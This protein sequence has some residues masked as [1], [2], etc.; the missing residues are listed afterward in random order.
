MYASLN[1]D[2]IKEFRRFLILKAIL[3]DTDG[4]RISPSRLLENAWRMLLLFPMDYMK[5]CEDLIPKDSQIRLLDY[6]P[7]EKNIIDVH[8]L[9]Y[10][11]C[12]HYYKIYFKEDPPQDIWPLTLT[13]SAVVPPISEQT[14]KDILTLKFRKGEMDE[15]FS[16]KSETKILKLLFKYS[17]F[18]KKPLSAFS[19]LHENI[20]LVHSSPEATIGALNLGDD[21]VIIVLESDLS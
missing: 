4:S 10:Y 13:T 18:H 20:D 15:I 5:L 11:N 9:K 1:D 16:V 7:L 8:H 2:I 14:K 17:A 19:F 3:R 12:L 21:P 6:N